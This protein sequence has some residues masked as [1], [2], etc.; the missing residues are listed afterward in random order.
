MTQEYLSTK[1]LMR[2]LGISKMTVWRWEKKGWLPKASR[3]KGRKPRYKRADVIR[4][5]E[6]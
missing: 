1:D 6:G 3:K 2:M 5:I 4:Y